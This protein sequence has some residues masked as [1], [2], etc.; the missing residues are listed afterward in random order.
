MTGNC[1]LMSL[2]LGVIRCL[3]EGTWRLSMPTTLVLGVLVTHPPELC[4][5]NPPFILCSSLL[6]NPKEEGQSEVD[7]CMLLG[8]PG[9]CVC[10]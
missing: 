5:V 4:S 2:Y 3:V 1:V 9:H 8:A 6:L 7:V 10:E